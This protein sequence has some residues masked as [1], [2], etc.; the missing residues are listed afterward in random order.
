MKNKSRILVMILIIAA[1][2]LGYMLRGGTKQETHEHAKSEEAQAKFWTCSM[3]PQIRQPGP[4][5]CPLCAMDLIAVKADDMG[6]TSG[7]REHKLSAHAMKLAQ[8][9]TAPVERKPVT[10]EIRLDGKI[11]FDETRVAHITAWVP[12]RIERLFVDYT[13]V[14]VNK[15]EHLVQLYSPELL[16][17]QQE[18][19][20][21]LKMLKRAAGS[22]R[23]STQR[24]VEATREK[25]RLWGLTKQQIKTIE[26]SG[27]AA[28]RTTVYSPISGIVIEKKGFEGMYVQTGTRIYTVADLSQVWVL[29]DAYEADLMWIRYGQEVEFETKA[30]PGERFNGKITFIDPMLNPKTRTVKVRVNVPNPDAKLKPEMFVSARIYPR[31]AAAG[32]VMDPALAGKWV[33]PMHPE[34]VKDRK[35]ACDLCGMPLVTAESLGYV[36]D[37]ELLGDIPL[38]IPA[39]APL[40]TGKR[41]VVYVAVPYKE[42][43]FEGREVVLGPR[44]GD[45]YLVEEGLS[46]GEMIVVN[47]SFKIDSALQIHAKPSMMGPEGGAPGHTHHGAKPKQ[48]SQEQQG[49]FAA[50]DAF[51]QSIDTLVA[52]YFGVHE[53]LSR[54]NATAAAKSVKHFLSR[55]DAVDMTL[56]KGEAH[57]AWMN[58]QDKLKKYALAVSSSKDISVFRTRFKE[59]SDTL[60]SV[61]QKFGTAGTIPVYRFHCPMAFDSKGAYWLQG[62]AETENPYYGASMFRCGSM[63]E[64]IAAGPAGKKLKEAGHE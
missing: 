40:I 24:N 9:R 59:L 60:Y 42:G 38:V 11:G 17:T 15:G 43:V 54:D 25:L 47:G 49:A 39:S 14:G 41:A 32:R 50:P 44:A 46:A 21:G 58:K 10:A 4:G 61:T 56:L 35:A 16:T 20:V 23:T 53:G 30:Y 36:S 6:K 1:F 64:T 48:A 57:S 55:L 22:L 63:K 2:A 51:R 52:A 26:T 3:H 12:G 18:L 33:C 5:Q 31:V 8:I 27:K 19:L 29:L 45:Y 28:D 34:I 7:A 37:E 13:G 62:S